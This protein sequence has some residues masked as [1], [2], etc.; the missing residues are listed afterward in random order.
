MLPLAFLCLTGE[1]LEPQAK[2][3]GSVHLRVLCPSPGHWALPA[4]G[5]VSRACGA[6]DRNPPSQPY[7]PLQDTAPLRDIEPNE[8]HHCKSFQKGVGDLALSLTL[9]KQPLA[10]L[11]GQE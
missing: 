9:M 5:L 11:P 8:G 1:G 6:E 4:Q 2:A 10:L 3:A 7:R